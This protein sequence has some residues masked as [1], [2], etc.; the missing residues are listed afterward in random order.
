MAA[1][2]KGVYWLDE[3]VEMMME[4]LV[5]MEAGERVMPS[6][7]ME[8]I[9]LFDQVAEA[10]RGGGFRR[11]GEQCRAKFKREKALFF[12]ALEDWQGIPPRGSRPP[13]FNLMRRL[14]E[15]GGRP[16]W[17]ERRPEPVEYISSPRETPHVEEEGERAAEYIS[18]PGET[19]HVEE[20][21]ERA[22]EYISSPG[23]TAHVEEEGERAVENIGGP[24][25]IP[26]VEEKGDTGHP[27]VASLSAP[28]GQPTPVVISSAVDSEDGGSRPSTSQ[29]ALQN[30]LPGVVRRVLA[31]E[32]DL[33]SLKT[34]VDQVRFNV[35]FIKQGMKTIN[36]TLTE[37]R[38][39]LALEHQ[40]CEDS[41]S[42]MEEENVEDQPQ[43]SVDPEDNQEGNAEDEGSSM[44]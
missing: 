18:S 13:R 1:A 17:R 26:S 20:E 38:L 28:E 31:L 24:R 7:H 42:E 19:A 6:T 5:D 32:K 15:Q 30:D 34:T 21:G 25:Q 39:D 41:G 27:E 43:V 9:S 16:G 4:A 23:E 8:T 14:W 11:S 3:E 2:R 33:K 10:M 40:R 44:Q 29:Q 37:M 22:A 36:Q 12:D 35:F